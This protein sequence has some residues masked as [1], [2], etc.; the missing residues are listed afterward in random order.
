MISTI[1]M[2]KPKYK[3]EEIRYRKYKA[4]DAETFGPTLQGMLNSLDPVNMSLDN[5]VKDMDKLI[6]ILIDVYAPEQRKLITRRPVK[7]W[8]TS[9]LKFMK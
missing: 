1:G 8:Y 5:L 6:N 4:I 3:W 7:L 2:Q 9:C